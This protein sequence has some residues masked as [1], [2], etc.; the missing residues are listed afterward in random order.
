FDR[1]YKTQ[2][3]ELIDQGVD[4]KE[5]EKQAPILKQA[6][7]MLRKWEAGDAEV[8]ELWTTMNG[9]VYK[10]FNETYKNLGVDFDQLYYESNT[11]LLG[12]DIVSEGLEKG[13]FFTKDD[14]SVWIDL[15]IGRA[16]CR[17]RVGREC[18]GGE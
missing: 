1:V 12:K 18:R 15:K 2:I 9:W 14:G 6:Q 16:S 17:E 11:Y 7:E 10:G 4:K 13:V 8:V 3:Q 5:A